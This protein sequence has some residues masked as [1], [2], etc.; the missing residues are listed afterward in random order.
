M[1]WAKR[2]RPGEGKGDPA[3]PSLVTDLMPL[4]VGKAVPCLVGLR[5]E[6]SQHIVRPGSFWG[7]K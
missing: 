2:G 4:Q 1:G 6:Y 3:E 7:L 5:D